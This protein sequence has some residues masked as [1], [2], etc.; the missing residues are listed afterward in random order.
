MGRC[1][2]DALRTLS[3]GRPRDLVLPRKACMA[4]R[5]V[6]VPALD[7]RPWAVVA[8]GL[9]IAAL[10]TT[11]TLWAIRSR[12]RGPLASWLLF[13]GT[14]FPALGFVSFFMFTVTFVADH[15]QYLAS[16]ELDRLRRGGHCDGPCPP[17]AGRSMVRHRLVCFC[18]SSCSRCCLGDRVA[19][20][21]ILSR[22][23]SKRLK[24]IPTHGS[25]TTLWASRCMTATGHRRQLITTARDSCHAKFPD[26]HNNLGTALIDAGKLPEAIDEL[27][28][29]LALKPNDPVYL[30]NLGLALM[31]S[32]RPAEAVDA[33]HAPHSN[34]TPTVPLLALVWASR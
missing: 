33:F 2:A 18:H 22:Y 34:A 24:R 10:V 12:W 5:S 11:F 3:A 28:A 31:N 14:L 16:I 30:T 8:I 21:P 25:H 29:A 27:R 9:P 17:R 7:P 15:I 4:R 23:V 13:C 6:Y 32:G 19:L 26:P 20:T 1:L